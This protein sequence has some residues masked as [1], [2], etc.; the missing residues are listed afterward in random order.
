MTY[1]KSWPRIA[2]RLK[3]EADWC[4]EEC[5]HLHDPEAGYCLT[6][7]HKDGDKANCTRENLAVLCQRCHLRRQA[8]LRLYGPE[9]ERQLRLPIVEAM[10]PTRQRQ[11]HEPRRITMSA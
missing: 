8:R 5:G 10:A 6:V 3:D 11:R 1:P 9:D 7:H 2:A 4:C